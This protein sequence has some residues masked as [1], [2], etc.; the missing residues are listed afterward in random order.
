M[1]QY[2]QPGTASLLWQCYSHCDKYFD[3]MNSI[4]TLTINLSQ[5]HNFKNDDIFV[6]VEINQLQFQSFFPSDNICFIGTI[7]L[8]QLRHGSCVRTFG[9]RRSLTLPP[10]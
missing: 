10:F 5:G 8:S 1:S 4:A 6:R 9:V 3:I 7:K 2:T